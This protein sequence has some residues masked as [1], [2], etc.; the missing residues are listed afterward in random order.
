MKAIQLFEVNIQRSEELLGLHKKIFPVGR[1]VSK[2]PPAELLRA[3][4][5]FVV[6][7]L[8][9]YIHKRITEVVA[10]ILHFKKRVPE[11]CVERISKRFKEKD[12]YREILNLALQKDPKNRI[13]HFLEESLA[14][15]TFQ[16]P[17][18]IQTALDMMEVE[19]PWKQI[20]RFLQPTRGRKKKGRRPE[21]KTFLLS[22]VARRDDIV[23]KNDMYIGKKYHGKIKPITRKEVTYSLNRLRQVVFAIEKIS[24]KQTL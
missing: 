17:E 5:V 20:N 23:H 24:E 21:A 14:P 12:G 16:K 1:P 11:K 8:D 7:A 9:A 4:V 18:Q 22:L 6:A 19:N 10:S 3:V 13:L 2:G 15:L